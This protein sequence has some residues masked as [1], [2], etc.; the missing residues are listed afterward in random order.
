M[1]FASCIFLML[2]VCALGVAGGA[3]GAALVPTTIPAP[4]MIVAAWNYTPDASVSKVR[5]ITRAGF[6]YQHPP[7]AWD[8]SAVYI[9]ITVDG[10]DATDAE[11]VARLKVLPVLDI[12]NTFEWQTFHAQPPASFDR[13]GIERTNDLIA[14]L[15]LRL[16]AAG[17]S[18]H[19]LD[20]LNVV[21]DAENPGPFTLSKFADP[22]GKHKDQ[23]AAANV[24]HL[25]TVCYLMTQA[26][27]AAKWEQRDHALMMN[28]N[29]AHTARPPPD[30][31]RPPYWRATPYWVPGT[32]S[33]GHFHSA[34]WV[35][36]PGGCLTEAEV[37]DVI[38][39][40]P[41]PLWLALEDNNPGI[42]N[43]LRA[44]Q[45]SGKVRLV[46]LW[47]NGKGDAMTGDTGINH[48][49]IDKGGSRVWVRNQDRTIAEAVGMER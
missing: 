48:R 21:L 31:G 42:A 11:A 41:G 14:S 38:G 12:V 20:R 16:K 6:R 45:K 39:R 25:A 40:S 37:I 17:L 13:A 29:T 49:D 5:G 4:P 32:C 22:D 35:G 7:G 9:A 18:E 34:Y 3:G 10:R 1:R 27:A 46:L 24:P 15:R 36:G 44:A 47:G 43:I 8:W 23:P 26:F 28:Y 19:R 2:T 33:E 30:L